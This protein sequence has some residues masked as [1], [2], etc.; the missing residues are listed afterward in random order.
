VGVAGPTGPAGPKGDSGA[1]G[2]AGSAGAIGPPGPPFGTLTSAEQS[3]FAAKAIGENSEAINN[4]VKAA[5]QDLKN[6]TLWCADGSFCAVPGQKPIQYNTSTKQ[7]ITVVKNAAG[8]NTSFQIETEPGYLQIATF[9]ASGKWTSQY[10]IRI[11]Q[12]AGSLQTMN[13]NSNYAA[14]HVLGD[15]TSNGVIFKNGTTRAAD[16][17]PKTLTL[18]NDDGSLR[19]ASSGGDVI[20][21]NNTLVMGDQ[22]RIYQDPDNNLAIENSATKVKYVVARQPGNLSNT[23]VWVNWTKI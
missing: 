22:W 5:N 9:D 16:G 12:T 19:L 4:I 3:T 18:R 2:A 14:M 7:A 15:G 8:T 11:S 20:I 13:Y 21:P 17:G 23:N 6:S 10:P 1:V